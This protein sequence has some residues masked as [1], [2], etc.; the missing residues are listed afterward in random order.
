MKA[1]IIL[2]VLTF[3]SGLSIRSNA[4]ITLDSISDGA[5][6]TY[7]ASPNGSG[8]F[9]AV[10][11][12]HGGLGTVVGGDLR[13]TVIALAEAGY[14]ARAEKRMETPSIMGHLEEVEAALDSLRAD[15]RADTTCVSIM[16]FSRGGYLTIEAAKANPLKVSAVIAM[17]PANPTGLLSTLVMDVSPIDDPVLLMVAQN[18]TFQGAHVEW[19][20]M[21]YDSLIS[22]GKITYEIIYPD[23]DS[24]GNSIIDPSDDGHLLFFEVLPLYWQDVL[25]FLN[26]IPCSSIGIDD[27]TEQPDFKIYPNPSASKIIVEINH[28]KEPYTILIYNIFGQKLYSTRIKEQKGQIQLPNTPGIYLVEF[29]SINKVYV[30]KVIKE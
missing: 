20:E 11:Y 29:R 1:T 7:I 9:P 16:G 4:Q 23:Y 19:V 15:P 22:A 27:I 2:L 18:D 3:L 10:L 14:L 17:A 8:P 13:G 26:A 21:T 5:G 6:Y 25:N 24:N 30:K 12:N 28:Y